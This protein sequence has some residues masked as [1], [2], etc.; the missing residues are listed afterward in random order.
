MVSQLASKEEMTELEKAFTKLDAN[1][2]GKL[3]YEE[4]ING[5]KEIMGDVAA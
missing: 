4:L 5:F 2:D 1:G 3:S